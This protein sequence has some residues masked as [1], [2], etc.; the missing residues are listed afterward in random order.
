MQELDLYAR[1]ASAHVSGGVL[2]ALPFAAEFNRGLEFGLKSLWADQRIRADIAVFHNR[3]EHQQLQQFRADRG[4]YILDGGSSTQSGWET[5]LQGLVTRDLSLHA[6]YGRVNA[7]FDN[8]LK[9]LTPKQTLYVG[10][11]LH[12]QPLAN[13][14]R[15]LLRMD[16]TWQDRALPAPCLLGQAATPT[17]CSGTGNASLTQAVT[18]PARTDLSLRLTLDDI[19]WGR[20]VNGTLS[21]WMR[22]ALGRRQL[23]FARDLG[24]GT[25]MGSFA[26]PR[27][28]GVELT[29][30]L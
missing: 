5:E 29:L 26:D 20:L 12:F 21:V 11:E 27:T 15:P 28:F 17:G 25:V 14:I 18:L 23:Q 3:S 9:A 24:N 30:S 16:A 1:L 22:N 10:G 6:S 2:A 4:T 19:A 13:G 7:R 8:G